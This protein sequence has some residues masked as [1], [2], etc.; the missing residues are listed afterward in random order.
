MSVKFRLMRQLFLLGVLLLGF[1]GADAKSPAVSETA[2]VDGH[3]YVDLGLPS[4]LKWA[5]CNVGASSPIECGDY[6][7]LDDRDKAVS[8]KFGSSWKVPSREDLEELYHNCIWEWTTIEGVNGYKVSSKKSKKQ[9]IFL[10]AAGRFL[11][12]YEWGKKGEMGA[13]W[14]SGEGADYLNIDQKSKGFSYVG[15]MVK[16]SV[17]PV[18]E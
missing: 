17:R 7:D 9:F 12:A 14:C 8:S 11:G 15:P 13:Y 18:T 4:G 5:T 10:P 16:Q 3:A 2:S 1:V 6:I